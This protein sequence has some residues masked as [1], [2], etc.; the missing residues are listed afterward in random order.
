MTQWSVLFGL[1]LPME[2]EATLTLIPNREAETGNYT[3]GE[4]PEKLSWLLYMYTVNRIKL[5]GRVFIIEAISKKVLQ[6]D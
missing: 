6:N 1:K 4:S 5:Q 2:I 3:D